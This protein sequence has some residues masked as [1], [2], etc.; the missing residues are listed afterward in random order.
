[1]Q[2]ST[3]WRAQML[4]TGPS[5]STHAL[6]HILKFMILRLLHPGDLPAHG[7]PTEL[8]KASGR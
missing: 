3:G 7:N 2:P 8:V 5:H 4:A 1:M 6:G